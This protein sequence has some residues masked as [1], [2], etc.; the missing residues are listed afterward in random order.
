M[1]I[2][3]KSFRDQEETLKNP[4]GT[5]EKSSRKHLELKQSFANPLRK[6]K[7]ILEK[8]KGNSSDIL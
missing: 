4:K 6:L 1:D 5:F 2:L 3:Y 7:E 8:S